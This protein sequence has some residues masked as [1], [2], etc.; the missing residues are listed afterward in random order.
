MPA[1]SPWDKLRPTSQRENELR[2]IKDDRPASASSPADDSTRPVSIHAHHYWSGGKG[3]SIVR[4]KVYKPVSSTFWSITGRS[5]GLT[6]TCPSFR[7][8]KQICH[9]FTRLS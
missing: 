9:G 2:K 5:V 8:Q 1:V 4:T 3:N 6:F 7:L